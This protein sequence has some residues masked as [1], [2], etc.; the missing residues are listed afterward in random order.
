[1]LTS[2]GV[3]I[4][5]SGVL[6]FLSK[7]YLKNDGDS[8]SVYGLLQIQGWLGL[9]ICLWGVWGI[10]YAQLDF[11]KVLTDLWYWL[12]ILLGGFI[13]VYTGGLLGFSMI[14]RLTLEQVP[15]ARAGAA[16]RL[17][18]KLV[19]VQIYSSYIVCILGLWLVCY[20]LFAA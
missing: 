2:F 6:C 18:F 9:S 5:L 1:M 8:A 7:F 17:R 20:S 12:S 4:I 16:T 15:A 19:L 3:V 14:Q 11:H 10:I 13:N